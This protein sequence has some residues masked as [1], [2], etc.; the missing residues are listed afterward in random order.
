[1]AQNGT[2]LAAPQGEPVLAA[3]AGKVLFAG[4]ARE[5]KAN[6]WTRFGNIVVVD[7]GGKVV[8][9][10][11]HLR[12]VL[13]RRGQAV[14]RAQ[15]LGSVGQTGWTRVPALYYEVRWPLDERSRPIDPGLVTPTVPV[16]DLDARLAD[17]TAG[18]PGGFAILD[19]LIGGRGER[20]PRARTPRP[21]PEQPTPGAD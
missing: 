2:T 16:E 9:V 4:S 13:V 14:T 10:Y 21:A 15:R 5:R 11:A 17:P 7:H 19:H 1:M 18:L 6:E 3:G 8:T 12:D 20:A